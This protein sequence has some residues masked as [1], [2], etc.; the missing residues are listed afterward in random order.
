M[1]RELIIEVMVVVVPNVQNKSGRKTDKIISFLVALNSLNHKEKTVRDGRFFVF[2][3]GKWL[4]LEADVAV[5]ALVLQ[6][7]NAYSFAE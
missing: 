3:G 2:V 5:R 1:G 4:G 7:G 6:R